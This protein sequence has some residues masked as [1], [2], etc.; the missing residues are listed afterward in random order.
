MAS[1][2]YLGLARLVEEREFFLDL[3]H[4][5]HLKYLE[6]D[7]EHEMMKMKEVDKLHGLVDYY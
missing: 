4:E 6:Q 3:H 1:L 2:I 7:L 5:F